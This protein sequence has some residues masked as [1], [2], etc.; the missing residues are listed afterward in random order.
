MC[1]VM[2]CP[3]PP[4]QKHLLRIFCE[5]FDILFNESLLQMFAEAVP[6]VFGAWHPIVISEARDHNERF[7]F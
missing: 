4:C 1:L 2:R 7:S 5:C 3:L 6:E